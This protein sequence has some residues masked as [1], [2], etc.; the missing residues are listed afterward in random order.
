MAASRLS[1]RARR[2]RVRTAKLLA[3]GVALAVPLGAIGPATQAISAAAGTPTV[4]QA[5]MLG[6]GEASAP[7]QRLG[8]G[9]IP[10]AP[11][12]KNTVKPPSLRS[13]FPVNNAKPADA[14]AVQPAPKDVAALPLQPSAVKGFDAKT[15]REMPGKRDRFTQTFANADTSETT[16]VSPAPLNFKKA[17]GT[18]AD[19]DPNLQP[20]DPGGW[21]AI[22][23]E[24][25]SWIAPKADADPV[26]RIELGDGHTIGWGVSGAAGVDGQMV[27]NKVLYPEFLT[28]TDLELESQ[29]RGIKETIVLKT[30]TA[31]RSHVFPLSLSG[32]LTA[33]LVGREVVLTDER[34]VERARIPAGTMEDSN[35][36]E[37][38]ATSEAVT[39]ELVTVDGRQ[40]LKVTADGTWL[41]DPARVFPVRIDPTVIPTDRLTPNYA[42]SAGMNGSISGGSELQLGCRPASGNSCTGSGWNAF[43]SL[44][45]FPNLVDAFRYDTIT[46]ASLEVFNYQADTCA[47]RPVEVY[48]TMGSWTGTPL[49]QLKYPGPQLTPSVVAGN[50]F[51]RGY[52][53]NVSGTTACQPRYDPLDFNAAGIAWLQSLVDGKVSN[54]GFAMLAYQRAD[55]YSWKKFAGINTANPPKLAVTHSPYNAEYAFRKQAPADYVTQDKNGKFPMTI[56]NR[57][58]FTWQPG[59]DYM[60][61]RVYTSTGHRVNVPSLATPVTTSV[62]H[63]GKINL[64]VEVG[65]LAGSPSGAIYQIEF[66]M[67]HRDSSIHKWYTDWGVLPKAKLIGVY[68]VPPL[69]NPAKVWP[70]NGAQAYSL[71]PQIWA[72]GIDPDAPESTLQYRFTTCEVT[73]PPSTNGCITDRFP[74]SSRTRVIPAGQ[75][76]WN[77]EY[78]WHFDITDND[79]A[80]TESPPITLFTDVPQPSIT[81]HLANNDGKSQDKPYDPA[82]GN[83]TTSALDIVVPVAGPELN[84]SRTYNSLDPRRDGLF[85]AGWSSRYDMRLVIETDGGN[86]LVNYPDGRQVR[87]GR[88]ADGTF[89]APRG[90]KSVL[91]ASGASGPWTLQIAAGTRYEFAAGTGKLSKIY[92]TQGKPLALTYRANGTLETAASQDG[93]GRKLTF[94][95]TADN[96][97]VASV[98]TQPVG[99]TALTW[100]YEYSGDTLTRSCNSE[101]ECTTYGS[102]QGSHYRSAV[103]DS[104]PDGY[105]RMSDDGGDNDATNEIDIVEDDAFGTYAGVQFGQVSSLAAVGD[106]DKS[107]KFT[108]GSS[109][110]LPNGLATRSRDEAVEMWF[111]T[112]GTAVQPLLGYQTNE[113]G[114]LRGGVPVLYVGSDGKLHG[115]FWQGSAVPMISSSLVNDDQWHHV[116]LSSMGTRQS[117]YL[118]GVGIDSITQSGVNH[119]QFPVNFIGRASVVGPAAWPAYGTTTTQHFL[120]QIDEVAL[121]SHPLTTREVVSHWQQGRN[122]ADQLSSVTSAAGRS[123]AEIEYNP[124]KD[125]VKR[126]V[127]ANGGDWTIGD[128]EVTGTTKDLVRTVNVAGPGGASYVYEYDALGGWLLRTGR[129]VAADTRKPWTPDTTPHWP[130]NYSIRSFTHDKT[131]QLTKVTGESGGEVSMTYDDRGN[132]ISTK[133]CRALP[134]SDC[135]TEY[136]TYHANAAWLPLDPRW[137][138]PAAFRDGRSA[139]ATDDTYKRNT[140]VTAS[141]DASAESSPGGGYKAYAYTDGVQ[142]GPDGKPMPPGLLKTAT[143]KMSSTV[144][145]STQYLYNEHGQLVQLTAPSGLVT[146]YTYDEIGRKRTETQVSDTYPSGVTT[147]YDYDKMSRVVG[148]TGPVTTDAVTGEQHQQKADLEYDDD[149]NVTKT[150]AR[151]LK[152]A[153]E[154]RVASLEYDDRNRVSRTIDADGKEAQQGYDA[155][156]NR[157]WSEDANGNRFEYKYSDLN[158]PTEVWDMNLPVD[159]NNPPA[160]ELREGVDYV[161]QS[162]TQYDPAGR[163]SA[164]VDAMGRVVT[165]Q[166]NADDTLKTKTLVGFHN[167]DGTTRDVVLEANTYDAA[168]NRIQAITDNDQ[169]ITAYTIDVAGRVAAEISDPNGLKRKSTYTH[170]LAGNIT[171][172]E[173]TGGWS[174]ADIAGPTA[175]TD[176]T[177]YLFDAAGRRVSQTVDNTGGAQLTTSWTFDQRGLSSSMTT[178]RGNAVGAVKADFTTVYG[179]DELGRQVKTVAPK[180]Q[181]EQNGGS[182]ADVQPTAFVGYGAFGL[183][184]SSKDAL[185]N[186]V[187]SSFD[188]L[189]RTVEVSAPQYT[190]PGGQA[191]TPKARFEYD[192]VGNV[193]AQIDERGN[194][195]RFTYDHLNQQVQIDAPGKTNDERATTKLTYTPNGDVASSTDPLGAVKKLTYDDLDRVVTSTDVERKPV[196]GNFVTR[197]TY[198]DRDNVV[199]AQTP[200]GAVATSTYDSLGQVTQSNDPNGVITKLGYDYAGRPVRSTDGMGRSSIAVYDRVGQLVASKTLDPTNAALGTTQLAYDADGNLISSTP[201]SGKRPTIYTYDAGGR[202]TKQVDPVTATDSITIGYGYDAAGNRTR[203]TDGRGN[204]TIS[205]VNSLGLPEKVIES[206]TT[207]HP[208]AADR[209]WTASYDAAGNSISLLSPG[210]VQRTRTYDAA[211]RLTKEEGTGAE[212]STAT[213][214]LGYDLVGRLATSSS[215]DGVNTYNYNDR[216]MLLRADGP[217]GTSTQGYDADGQLTQRI[218]A[219][220]TADFTY[221]NGRPTTVTDPVTR[222]I[223]TLGYNTAGQL[224][225]INYGSN[226]IRTVGYDAFGRMNSDTLKAGATAVSSITYGYD[227]D[228]NVTSKKTTGVAGAGDNTYAYDQLGRLTSW[229]AGTKTTEYGWDAAS[230]RTK[231]GAKLATYDERNRLINDGTSTYTY[232]A[233]GALLSKVAGATTEAFTFDAFDRMIRSSDRDFAYDAL[234]RPVQAGTARMRYDGFSDEVVS[235]GTQFFGRS[236]SDGLLAVGY[237]TTKRLVLADRHGDVFGGFDPTDTTLATGLPDSRT[238]D[239]FGNSTAA[240][241]LKYRVGYQGDWTDPRSGDVNQGARWYNPDSGTFNSRDTMTYN[242]GVASSLPN[243]YAYGAGNPLTFNDPT[244]NRVIDPNSDRPCWMESPGYEMRPVKKCDPPKPPKPPKT[245]KERGDCKKPPKTCKE[246]GDC[247]KPPKTCKERGDCKKPPKST[248]KT[249]GDC[250]K[251][252]EICDAECQR[253][254]KIKKEH[255]RLEDDAKNKDHQPPGQPSCANGNPD[256]CPGNPNKPATVVGPENDD[257][258][259]NSDGA[260]TQYQNALNTTGSVI[261]SVGTTTCFCS[262]IGGG[263]GGGGLGGL[264]GIGG[265]GGL[266]GGLTGGQVIGGGL[267]GA[268]G[269]LLSQDDID[270]NWDFPWPTEVGGAAQPPDPDEEDDG[271][272]NSRGAKYPQVTD[273]RTG[274]PIHNPGSGLQK[275][276]LDKRVGWDSSK[277]RYG[278]IKE[279]HDRGFPE[280]KG[281][282]GKYDIHHIKPREYGGD[283]SFDNLVPVE[284]TVHQQQFNPWWQGY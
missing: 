118:D 178:P 254:K 270:G 189:G 185:G 58:N 257:T 143:V 84:V 45:Y 55:R 180:V 280:P 206:S 179:Y 277:D 207:A 78:Q 223:Q 91:T 61:Y 19:I 228:N 251:P 46:A 14:T 250:P 116:V 155:A 283:N 31:T 132:V 54:F 255:D 70:L 2:S 174:N 66:S 5:V 279:W 205:T 225:T 167:P 40:A 8:A 146:K 232:S 252:P 22:S 194:A 138:K 249:R 64:N 192:A 77:R 271:P 261:E 162:K 144:N 26:A 113:T 197:L 165:Y 265:R 262:I 226:R 102:T 87:F 39:Y 157:T 267:L 239:P 233:R 272:T 204:S 166:Y 65:A 47:S 220:G 168:G 235:D 241:G 128:P 42:V 181:A 221:T 142:T 186:V 53:S 238:Y 21:E 236:A 122:A 98:S 141:G 103:L 215:L 126:Y 195:T 274:K 159:P 56:T 34:G 124:A 80:H 219:A 170:D 133:T 59:N 149:G 209:T 150:T 104:K 112:S 191:V 173:T 187:K 114:T 140:N 208:A 156:G 129:P 234:D 230:N 145:S 199:N 253:K 135:R 67:V 163:K 72:D 153:D 35:A 71:T 243:L 258:D 49:P 25:Y 23:T 57:G 139:S 248:C 158:M 88:N 216:G 176:V 13:M 48:G 106:A 69:V 62:A 4:P 242:A 27:G 136:S 269:I 121:Y 38:H 154:P 218:D 263:G 117:L 268:G 111:K 281:G 214:D 10:P 30:A 51:S 260:D 160:G 246:R 127:D 107:V 68:N 16:V 12:P 164:E 184:T 96:K 101:Q 108:T 266:L 11:A 213:R 44:L 74:T 177:S 95:W 9:K 190:P 79:G 90:T 20:A 148:I 94:N 33:A 247:K 17:D 222:A 227:A 52:V 237:D 175:V 231:N 89:A 202:L 188:K 284:R 6:R 200:S 130:E 50:S 99:G 203:Y 244:G 97:H 18:W 171:K 131:G 278:F 83:Y 93:A 245:C 29:P 73:T 85:G 109:V 152:T 201:A 81:S 196:A 60:S 32:N 36:V 137:D 119:E 115:Q 183:A 76:E 273:P 123:T 41:D 276:P 100:T 7:P 229:T 75:L 125:R 210:G 147:S 256:L 172:E 217:S 275:V 120:G 24:L 264:G 37:G 15:S 169:S 161:V 3:I 92:S 105:F 182:P 151:D 63:G 259:E 134:A 28:G 211:G 193:L 43:T 82:V 212:V 240:N 224:A 1:F 86:A 110:K 282:W 198:D